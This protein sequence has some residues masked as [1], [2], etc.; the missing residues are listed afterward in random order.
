M[1]P[2][3]GRSQ[4]KKKRK[5][6]HCTVWQK[7]DRSSNQYG[8]WFVAER[9]HKNGSLNFLVTGVGGVIEGCDP[10]R[11]GSNNEEVV[12]ERIPIST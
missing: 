7:T 11:V 8:W 12:Q 9:L 5:K 4:H 6:L 3:I 1:P 2:R 10:A